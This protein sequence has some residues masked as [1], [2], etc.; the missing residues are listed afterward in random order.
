MSNF[1]IKLNYDSY[2][3]K[4]YSC[5]IGK[6]IGGTMGTPYECKREILDVKGFKTE[7][8]VVLPNDDLDLQLVWLLAV[9]RLGINRINSVTLGEFWLSYIVPHWNEYGIAKSNLEAG[10]M[11]PLSGDYENDWK[12]S[13]GAWIRTEIWACLAPGCPEIAAKY[14]IEDAKVDHGS[15][16]GTFAAALVA[17]IQSAAFVFK[18]LRKC[19][20]VG[21]SKIPNNCRMAD[22]VRT[23]LKCYDEGKT[24]VET[25][26]I[27]LERN[28][29][30]G[31]GWF[32]APSNVSYALIG[33]LWGEGDFKKSMLTAINCG[34]D[35]DCTAATVGAT[36]GILGG[37]ENIPSDWKKHIGDDIVTISINRGGV[38]RTV[39]STCTELSERVIRQAPAVIHLMRSEI[40]FVSGESEIPEKIM[41]KFTDNT[42]YWDV[43]DTIK[44]NTITV[45]S[46]FVNAIV[47][48][49]GD[50]EIT[51]NGE[52]KLHI[53]LKNNFGICDVKPYNLELRW[54]LPNGFTAEGA[55]NSITLPHFNAHQKAK[56]EFDVTIKAGEQV[57]AK[58]KIV[59]EVSAI[60]RSV[61]LY[62]P[63]ILIG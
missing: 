18:D 4:V 6:N 11:S 22:S 55:K 19:I 16:E 61:P 54:W 57:N 42:F 51:P 21:L 28:M 44:A 48:Y 43:L 24:W 39:P 31:D 49:D 60:G 58:N 56:C 30:I 53:T 2:K 34:D 8:N 32:E 62:V 14:A 40:E 10:L 5:W 47:T 27:I 13:N 37:S 36:L 15:G 59:L 35:T 41:D 25:R 17:A 46:V 9:E 12:H 3:D 20:E 52:K 26:N 33:L 29:D 23:V 45:E 63:I 1:R 7:A 38:G 50:P